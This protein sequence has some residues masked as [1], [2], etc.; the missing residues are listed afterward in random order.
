[1]TDVIDPIAEIRQIRSQLAEQA[2]VWTHATVGIVLQPESE[3]PDEETYW[4]ALG[5]IYEAAAQTLHIR[6][7]RGD[8]GGKHRSTARA[9]TDA[10]AY[11][12]PIPMLVRVNQP[13]VALGYA[14]RVAVLANRALSEWRKS[15]R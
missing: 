12:T 1:M 6:V 3:Q 15:D 7:T 8:I 11:M 10:S 4:K 5:A 14:Q 2:S 9:L 13:L